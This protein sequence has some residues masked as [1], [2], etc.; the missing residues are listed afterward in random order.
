VVG[1]ERE[2]AAPSWSP[3]SSSI[4]YLGGSGGKLHVAVT[5]VGSQQ[6]QFLLP[7]T[8]NQCASAPVWSP[9]GRWIA[10]GGF[11][12]TVLLVSPDGKQHRSLPS[13][14]PPAS[15]RFVLV[16]S[17]DAEMIYVASSHTQ[18][19]RLDAIDVRTGRS[20]KIVEYPQE[21]RISTPNTYSLSGSLSRDAKSFATTVVNTKSDLWILEG[22]PQPRRHWF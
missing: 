16:W 3:D 11:S 7:G 2:T 18:K 19:A 10:C 5:R 20:R 9:D 12:Q 4:T 21:L 17:R 13:P 14:V 15:N 8:A 22:F 6:P 1:G